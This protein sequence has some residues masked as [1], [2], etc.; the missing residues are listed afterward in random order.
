MKNEF[1]ET[2][3]ILDAQAMNLSYHQKRYESVLKHFGIKK[4]RCLEELMDPPKEGLYR[5]RVV[6][7]PQHIDLIDVEYV[8][9]HKK[10]IRTL[11]IIVDEEIDYTFKSTNRSALDALYAKKEEA[12]DILIIKDGYITDTSIANIAFYDGVWKTPQHPLL[13]GTTR[14]RY[15]D[16]GK[17]FVENI[18]VDE[19]KNFSKVAL[20]NAMIDFDIIADENIKDVFC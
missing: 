8:K 2:I 6:Y 14:Q 10:K 4:F 18:R 13:K 16:Q 9:Y 15:L 20:L 1:L 19:I 3:R 5:S 7:S 11:K 12:E 17:L